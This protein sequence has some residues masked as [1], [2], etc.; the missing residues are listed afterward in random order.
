MSVAAESSAARPSAGS[1]ARLAACPDPNPE[2]NR[3]NE[4]ARLHSAEPRTLQ[5]VRAPRTR[6]REAAAAHNP[7]HSAARSGTARVWRSNAARSTLQTHLRFRS[8]VRSRAASSVPAE[9]CPC[10][11]RA[12]IPPPRFHPASAAPALDLLPRT[13]RKP[14]VL[15]ARRTRS[16]S[17]RP[18][19]TSLARRSLPFVPAP[20]IGGPAIGSGRSASSRRLVSDRRRD[21]LPQ[22][23]ELD[24][25]PSPQFLYDFV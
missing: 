2:T 3:H 6:F 24:R 14:V 23:R 21:Q 17:R 4:P 10:P 22:S 15:F 8:P 13:P 9:V 1:L 25:L 7:A 20:A 19:G 11:A 18:R 12:S 16:G 5:S